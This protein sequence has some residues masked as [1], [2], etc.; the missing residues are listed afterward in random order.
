MFTSAAPHQISPRDHRRQSWASGE[1][2]SPDFGLGSSGVAGGLW[3]CGQVVKYYHSLFSTGSML[4]S[5]FSS[6]TE[7]SAQNVQ[8]G[9]NGNL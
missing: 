1:S 5:G 2:R 7:K 3:G 8:V 6:K 9:V 4:E